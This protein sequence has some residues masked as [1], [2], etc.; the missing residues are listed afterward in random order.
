M[1]KIT[2]LMIVILI[3]LTAMMTAMVYAY[4][5]GDTV[6]GGSKDGWAYAESSSVCLSSIPA[7]EKS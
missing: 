1:K 4:A 7:P 2:V 6:K 3:A 5:P